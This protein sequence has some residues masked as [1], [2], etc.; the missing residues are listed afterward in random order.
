MPL[1]LPLVQPLAGFSA[2]NAEEID[3]TQV[4]AKTLKNFM[5]ESP[6]ELAAK[7]APSYFMGQGGIWD[8]ILISGLN[9]YFRKVKCEAASR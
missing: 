8:S 7:L 5:D 3:I 9:Y 1:Y 2:A 4:K 6:N